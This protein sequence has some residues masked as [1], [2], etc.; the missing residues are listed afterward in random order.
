M[1]AIS[2]DTDFLLK[3]LAPN[4]EAMHRQL[5]RFAGMPEVQAIR[6]FPVLGLSKDE[7][8]PIPEDPPTAQPK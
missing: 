3:C 4:V 6:S 5:L 7:P 1:P 2:G 8:L